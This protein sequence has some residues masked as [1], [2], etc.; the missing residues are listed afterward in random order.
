[1]LIMTLTLNIEILHSQSNKEKKGICGKFAYKKEGK[2]FY[3]FGNRFNK[4]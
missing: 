1:M 2:M 4:V 3:K